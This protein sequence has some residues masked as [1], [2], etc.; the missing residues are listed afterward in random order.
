MGVEPASR[1]TDQGLPA[2]ILPAQAGPLL[3]AL[4]SAFTYPT[5]RRFATLMAAALL[6]T[7][8][9]TVANPLRTLGGLAPGHCTSF[10]G[11][12]SSASWSGLRR[13][14]LLARFVLRQLPPR[15]PGGPRRRRHRR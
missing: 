4:A 6:T 11:V 10:Q 9:R 14:T 7:G 13:G 12:L 8:R 5:F 1:A 15:R 3:R 2:V